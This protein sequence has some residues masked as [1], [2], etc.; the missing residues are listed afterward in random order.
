MT[1]WKILAKGKKVAPELTGHPGQILSALMAGYKDYEQLVKV[2]KPHWDGDAKK[3]LLVVAVEHVQVRV[4]LE[5]HRAGVGAVVAY[6]P[7]PSFS[8]FFSHV[9]ASSPHPPQRLLGGLALV[10]GQGRRHVRVA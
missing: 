9:S 10:E 5:V 1:Y 7:P 2:V 8:S 6:F 3:Q 4:H